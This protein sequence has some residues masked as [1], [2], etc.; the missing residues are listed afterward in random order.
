MNIYVGNLSHEVKE[1][2]L[3]TTFEPYGEVS[4]VKLIKD[5]FSGISKGFAFIEM[6]GKEHAKNAMDELNGKDLKGRPMR[7]NEARPRR[8]NRRQG[9]RGG[10]RRY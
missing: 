4:S 7:V 9:N 1:E 6:P 8:D 2:D 5:M 3:R 10:G